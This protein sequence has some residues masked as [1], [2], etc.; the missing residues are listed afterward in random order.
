MISRLKIY[1]GDEAYLVPSECVKNWDEVACTLERKDYSGVT[2]SFTSQF[3]FVGSVKELLLSLY[4]A[5]GFNAKAEIAVETIN[6]DWSFS[7]QFRCPLDFS[8]VEYDDTT[9][10]ISSVDDSLAAIIKAKKGVKY[11]FLL[12]DKTKFPHNE[13]LQLQRLSLRNN[14]LYNVGGQQ[15]VNAAKPTPLEMTYDKAELISTDLFEPTNSGESN[16]F[17]IT[18]KAYH[19]PLR[20]VYHF[21]F[22]AD[23][24]A[25]FEENTHKSVGLYVFAEDATSDSLL[26]ELATNSLSS[27]LLG[28]D[29]EG[30]L[31]R[32]LDDLEDYVLS[33]DDVAVGDFGVVGTSQ[34]GSSHYWTDNVLYE[35]NGDELVEMGMPKDYKPTIGVD[36]EFELAETVKEAR[37]SLETTTSGKSGEW[38]FESSYMHVYWEDAAVGVSWVDVIKP[39]WFIQ[40]LVDEMTGGKGYSVSF[41][42]YDKRL[43]M[44]RL[45]PGES[46]RGLSAAKIYSTF[47]E[48]C[49]WM[50]AV[51]G[52]TYKI[53]GKTLRFLHRSECFGNNVVKSIDSVDDFQYSVQD[54]L[55]Y[56]E[57]DCGYDKQDYD[58]INGRD[59]FNFT[60]YYTTGFNLDEKKLD[61]KS[62]YRADCYGIEFTARKAGQDTTDDKSDEKVFFVHI[63]KSSGYYVEIDDSTAITGTLSTKAYNGEFSP[64]ACAIAN[65]AYAAAV[66]NGKAMTL[67]AATAEG[68]T[69][70]LI[71]G[72]AVGAPVEIA[73]GTA[74]F[75][76]G[77]ISFTTGDLAIPGNWEGLVSVMHA[78]KRYGGYIKKAELRLGRSEAVSYT[79][80]VKTIESV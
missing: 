8:S 6:N 36:G 12:S 55:L 29:P 25:E 3:E 78:G 57:V 47:T 14:V 20:L 59:E 17:F 79:L 42:D 43:A 44:T 16:R 5:D 34:Y 4:E 66:A 10:S 45:L 22:T 75:T 65:E 69:T 28:G 40:A 9:L 56:S 19:V 49:N 62:K 26:A 38:L 46:I 35:W 53:D 58:S 63:K 31:F 7:E 37:Y 73:A 74:L 67:T 64:R 13:T 48:F 51:F 61:L 76:A 50:S 39:L 15:S 68:N 21:Q 2:R 11:S 54:N 52:Y 32:T 27:H 77:E 41:S 1:I 71:D 72:V 80:I 60:T 24:Y 30:G 33:S 23:F 70:V 18:S